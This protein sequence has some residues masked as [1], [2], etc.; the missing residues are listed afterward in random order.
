MKCKTIRLITWTNKHTRTIYGE[1]YGSVKLRFSLIKCKQTKRNN[2]FRFSFS[3]VLASLYAVLRYN[4]IIHAT[5]ALFLCYSYKLFLQYMRPSLFLFLYYG[6]SR[7]IMLNPIL[8]GSIFLYRSNFLHSALTSSIPLYPSLSL[9][10]PLYSTLSL[11]ISLYFTLFLSIPLY[12]A[13]FRS[14]SPSHSLAHFSHNV[15]KT[16]RSEK[17]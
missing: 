15:T 2:K 17:K 14:I 1:M 11:F 4:P 7:S 13:L 5:F 16:Q 3:F 12:P 6:L 9:S 10:I 8:F